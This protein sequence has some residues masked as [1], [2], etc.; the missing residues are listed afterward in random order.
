MSFNMEKYNIQLLLFRLTRPPVRIVL[1]EKK[2]FFR[3]M[4]RVE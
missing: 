3:Q 1:I 4:Y 2:I